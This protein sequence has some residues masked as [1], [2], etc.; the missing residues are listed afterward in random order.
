MSTLM[1]ADIPVTT[2]NDS[3]AG[4][5][6][7]GLAGA[8]SGDRLVFDSLVSGST[9]VNGSSLGFSQPVTMFAGTSLTLTDSH[10][11]LLAAPVTIDWAGTLNLNG[12]LSDGVVPGKLIKT[13]AGTLALS[14]TNSYTG[15]TVFNGGTIDLLNSSGLGTGSITVHNLVGSTTLDLANGVQLGNDVSLQTGLIV[16]TGPGTTSQMF[17]II[18]ESGGSFGLNK[19]G[20][21]TLILSGANTFSG[22]V[23]VSNDSTIRAENDSALG[24]GIVTVSGALT[25]DLANGINVGN[26]FS[27]SNN[28][29][30]N[31]DSGTATM[32]GLVDELASSSF[33]KTGAGSLIVTGTNTYTGL[34]TINAGELQVQGSITSDVSIAN[35]SA[36][37]SGAG[38]V[39]NVTNNGTVAPGNS[40]IGNLTVNGNFT[41]N[42][43]G[44]TNIE[45]NSTGNTPGVNNDHLTV[46]G[47]TSLDGTLNLIAV[48]G[49]LFHTGTNYTILNSTG[50]VSGQ[51][52]QVIDNLSMFNVNLIYDA[53]DVIVQLQQSSTFRGISTTGNQSNVGTALDTIAL[54][55]SGS[56]FNMINTLGGETAAD[57]RQSLNQLS[58]ELFGSTQTIGLQA[59]DQFQQRINSRLTN[60]GQ[61]LSGQPS[62]TESDESDVR[63]QSPSGSTNG[64]MLGYGVGG[65]LR[66]DGSGAGVRYSQGG[67]AYGIDWGADET[68]VIGITGGNSYVGFHDGFGAGGNLTSYQVGLY[69]LKHND[70]A[71]VIGSTN[72]GYNNFGSNRN[73]DVGGINQTLRGSF[74]G[75]QLGA[76]TETGLKLHAGW[77]HFQ[78]LVGLQYLYLAQQGF[79]ESGG[80]AA[81]NVSASQA[82]SLRTSLGGRIVVDQ[83]VGPWGTVWTPY[84]HGRWV[85]ELLDN[86]RIVN[87]SF[88]GAP[89]GG[90]FTAHGT[91]LGQNYAIISKGLQVQLTDQWSLYGN[92]DLMTFGRIE[93]ETGS[94]GATYTW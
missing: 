64:W 29:T 75:H 38:S 12:V 53:N 28:F 87:A 45:I 41:Q 15:G 74:V 4:S 84:W 81:L 63:G 59:G 23:Y 71:Y 35:S 88:N 11:F 44:K 5:L 36:V 86:D 30:A 9:L 50:G 70:V 83:L 82:N 25:L 26:H 90:T 14:G 62:V 60:N 40:G 22:G 24:S 94:F 17:G 6:R 19:T 73:V 68:G 65:S 16:N 46:S 72:Y 77:V 55:S 79:D 7:Q 54:T 58:G 18:S 21:G 78:P 43:G 66:S 85:S 2:V 42:A 20:S 93:T 49:G 57:Q 3:G 48:G 34:T 80:S 37:L 1:A 56:L 31:V 10:A 47:H 51:Y 67:A 39:G 69:A 13:G 33:T 91:R 76:Y 61:F 52:A 89:I 8:A 32:S 27:L 92:F